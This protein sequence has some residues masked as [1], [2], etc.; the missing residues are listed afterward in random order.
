LGDSRLD[1]N[2]NN[3]EIDNLVILQQS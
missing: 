3:Q 1:T 2:L